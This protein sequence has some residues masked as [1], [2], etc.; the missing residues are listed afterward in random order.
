[1]S[2][3][4]AVSLCCPKPLVMAGL[5]SI[6]ESDGHTVLHQVESTTELPSAV[7]ETRPDIALIDHDALDGDMSP[8]VELKSRDCRVVILANPRWDGKNVK[9]AL[10]AGVEGYL[11][12]DAHPEQFF[13]SL[14]LIADG[15]VVVSPDLGKLAWNE[16]TNVE[17]DGHVSDLSPRERQIAVLVAGGLSTRAIGEELGLSE[18]TVKAH[19]AH[20]LTKLNLHNRAQIAAYASLNGLLDIS[21]LWNGGT[22]TDKELDH[23]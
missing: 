22:E 17:L 3:P 12:T 4:L 5:A 11:S 9:P 10:Q 7:E 1:M 23:A 14:N 13:S 15:T 21:L 6:L 20:M 19:V 8:I 18:H 16:P 2:K